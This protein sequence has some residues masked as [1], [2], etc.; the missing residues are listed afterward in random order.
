MM[1]AVWTSEMQLNLYQSTRRYNPEDSH[2]HTQCCENFIS[3]VL[4]VDF[5]DVTLCRL[6]R[7][8]QHFGVTA[9]NM[10]AVCSSKML[11]PLTS[12]CSCEIQKTTIE[13][14]VLAEHNPAFGESCSSL[15]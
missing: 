12:S 10:E 6:A 2:L 11:I 7:R 8:Y 5:W 1:E 4:L 14:T 15:M 13:M 3:E 9:L